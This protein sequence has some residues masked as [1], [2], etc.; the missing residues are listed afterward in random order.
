MDGVGLVVVLLLVVVAEE[1]E[2]EEEEVVV[3]VVLVVLVPVV[4]LADPAGAEGIDRPGIPTLK[5]NGCKHCR[6]KILAIQ[7]L[8][9]RRKFLG[10]PLES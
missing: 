10:I 5:H 9:G 1:E 4:V 6:N 7:I 8:W 2:E 3:S